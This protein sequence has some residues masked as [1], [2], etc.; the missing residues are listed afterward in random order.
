MY[1]GDYFPIS[2]A[3]SALTK[4]FIIHVENLRLLFFKDVFM[5]CLFMFPTFFTSR[6]CILIC[7]WDLYVA[8]ICVMFSFTMHSFFHV[9]FN[10][11]HLKQDFMILIFSFHFQIQFTFCIVTFSLQGSFIFT[12][13]FLNFFWFIFTCSACFYIF[14]RYLSPRE[15]FIFTC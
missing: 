2:P 14:T 8:F 9:C 13:D 11:Q 5:F 4:K 7:T 1:V 10:F 6:A 3:S 12:F 15:S